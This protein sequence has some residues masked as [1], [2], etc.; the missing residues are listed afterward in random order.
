MVDNR[1]NNSL[2]NANKSSDIPD[3]E[4]DDFFEALDHRLGISDEQ[5]KQKELEET[6]MIDLDQEVTKALETL[7]EEDQE[8]FERTGIIHFDRTAPIQNQ[9]VKA[10]NLQKKNEAH[11]KAVKKTILYLMMVGI[12][13]CLGGLYIGSHMSARSTA[14][15]KAK[16]PYAV[17]DDEEAV[18]I[19]ENTFPDPV[20]REYIQK[21]ADTNSDGSLSP[22]ERNSVLVV[23][24]FGD[25]TL[26]SAKGI[27]YFPL[28]QALNLSNTGLI[29]I[30]L[31]GNHLLDNINLSNT[32][33]TVLD[34]SKAQ[35]LTKV[36]ISGTTVTTLTLPAP[37]KVTD[38]NVTNTT[39]SCTKS[40]DNYYNAC[41]VKQ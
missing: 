39:L 40:E 35:D 2:N 32:K 19:N 23:S 37:S 10:V 30:D 7:S 28:L 36:N 6:G 33:I 41:S 29:E 12:V 1:N 18:K 3:Q 11:Q 21:N 24:L 34:L 13:I 38:V 27:E 31:Q 25:P 17:A 20:F 5:L 8:V 15:S 9:V 16:N 14:S 4:E 22:D 26:T